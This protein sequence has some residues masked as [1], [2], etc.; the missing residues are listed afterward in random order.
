[1]KKYL[2]YFIISLISNVI[3]GQSYQPLLVDG[4]RWNV[5]NKPFYTTLKCGKDNSS[6][7]SIGT[8]ILSLTADTI[9]ING[10]IFRNLVSSFNTISVGYLSEDT[11]KHKVYFGAS[12]LHQGTILLYDF[13]AK[14]HDTIYTNTINIVDTIDSIKIGNQMHKRIRFNNAHDGSYGLYSR[15][16]WI[17]GIGASNG[18]ITNILPILMCGTNYQRTLLCLYNHDSLIYQTDSLKYMNCFYQK[19][20][21]GINKINPKLNYRIYPNPAEDYIIISSDDN[22]KSIVEISNIQGQ[23]LIKQALIND[24]QINLHKVKSGIYFVKIISDKNI[25]TYKIIK[26]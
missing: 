2:I 25:L 11:V 9:M 7:D 22:Q 17:E 16:D 24:N 26:E 21:V 4:N 5:L 23:I 13:D 1:M 6:S 19:T 14:I 15:I 12:Y 20:Y 10:V 8:E 3:S 18:L